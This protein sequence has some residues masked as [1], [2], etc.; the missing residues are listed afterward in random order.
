MISVC[1]AT[2][3]GE[4][5]IKEQLNSIIIQIS[6]EDEI[7]VSDDWSNDRTL[8]IVSNYQDNRIKILFNKKEK[9][10]SKNFENAILYAKGDIIFICDQDDVW[11]PNKVSRMIDALKK[12]TIGYS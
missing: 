5:Y 11:L 6:Q 1:I 12:S 9:G 10:Y 2:Y 4:K 3:N 7:V 8:E